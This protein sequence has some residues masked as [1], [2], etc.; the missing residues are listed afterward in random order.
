[1]KKEVLFIFVLLS[2]FYS[3]TNRSSSNYKP[4]AKENLILIDL[5]KNDKVSVYELFSEVEIITLETTSNSLLEFPMGE[6]DRVIVDDEKY[7][8]L[9]KKQ[10]AILIFNHEGKFLK[11][12]D[13]RGMGPK[14]YLS[15]HDFNINRFSKKIEV[16]SPEGRY[17]NIYDPSG[18]IF[19]ERQYLPKDMPIVHYFQNLTP[20]IYAFLSCAGSVEIVFY[21]RKDD[22]IIQSNYSLP[23]WISKTI[24]SISKNPFYIFN[25][26]LCFQQK[27]NGD[28]FTISPINYE[29]YPRY[30]WNFGQQNFDILST[31]P[32]DESINFYM[33]LSNKISMKFA[34]L[35]Q[36]YK[37]N[38]KYYITR[39]K[40]KNRHN[41]L[42]FDKF[43]NEY[44]LFEKFI[45]GGQLLPQWIDD[46]AIYTFVPPTFLN[47]VINLT[48][49]NKENQIKYNQLKEDDNPVII[50]YTFK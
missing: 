50:K 30:C 3:C 14:E 20:D 18:D 1:M 15:I 45:E 6:P 48:L 7:Y 41:H 23:E 2:I 32:K 26:S 39:F 17:I 35:F 33:E 9:D 27:Y 42:V 21:S 44:L 28:V 29:L 46:E 47:Q 4:L 36:I 11:K 13:Y 49:L 16:L 19:I 43:T 38:S 40:Y 8:F 25:D 37:E 12:M 10:Q 22:T 31:F 34:V 5:N 24:F